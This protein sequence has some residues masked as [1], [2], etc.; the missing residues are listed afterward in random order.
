M[1][2]VS[3]DLVKQ[4]RDQ[5]Q[6]GMMDCKKALEEANGD[7]TLAVEIL[8]KKGAAVAAKRAGNEATKGRIEAFISADNKTGALVE[9]GCETDFSANTTTMEAFANMTA[10]IVANNNPATVQDLMAIKNPASSLTLQESLDELI[11]KICEKIQIN[12][13]ARF[14][15]TDNGLVNAYI[16]PGS[17]VGIMIELQTATPATDVEALKALAKDLCMQIAVTNPLCIAPSQLDPVVLEKERSIAREQLATSN[18]PAAI[19]EKIVE[20]KINKFYEE[21][22]LLN[23]L[24]IKNDKLSVKAHVEEVAKKV[25]TSITVTQFKRCAIGR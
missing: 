24:F 14:A 19:I 4:L 21:V 1:A 2:A 6:V 25:G 15:I 9:V 22:C 18:K 10:E 8:R 12:Q 17:T 23:Q 16:H 7:L 20:G 3:M 5:T 13:F 11:A